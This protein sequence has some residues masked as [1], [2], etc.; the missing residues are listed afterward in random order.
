[1]QLVLQGLAWEECLAYLES[2]D[3]IILGH[4]FQDH[5]QKL[6]NV[7]EK[8]KTYNLKLKPAKCK[9]FQKEVKFLGKILNAKLGILIFL[10]LYSIYLNF[11][12]KWYTIYRQWTHV[13]R[14]FQ[15]YI[16]I[17]YKT[18]FFQNIIL[19]SFHVRFFFQINKSIK[20]CNLSYWC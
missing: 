6:E 18:T 17:T 9:L 19:Q 2:D 4:N 16:Y 5:T 15:F 10:N 14:H 11:M 13:C 8:F 1:M 3:V 12:I 20:V 7:F